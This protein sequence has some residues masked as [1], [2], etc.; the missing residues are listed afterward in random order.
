MVLSCKPFA[1]K[2]KEEIRDYLKHTTI[3]NREPCLCVIQVGDNPA[4]NSYIKGKKKDCEDVGIKFIHH[5]IVNENISEDEL[6]DIIN[7]YNDDN[8]VDGI[9]VQLPLPSHLDERIIC[10]C[11]DLFKDVDGF[12]D[13][14]IFTPCTP[15]GIMRIISECGI[16]LAG[17][18]CVMV[19]SGRVGRPTGNL[20]MD[21]KATVTF[22][23]SKTDGL[24]YLTYMADVI[25]V[26]AGRPH[27]IKSNWI[28]NDTLIIDVGIN[29]DENGKL[30]G[31]VDRIFD[32]HPNITITPVPG[33]VGLMTRVSLLEN[34][35][36]AYAFNIT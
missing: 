36:K 20:M 17:K 23:N 3:W 11:V 27:M 31:D 13:D 4:S 16:D 21:K 25:V 29:R 14:A 33:G 35:I 6:I 34:V 10:N 28:S 19:G 32:D 24:G 7:L 26:A 5:H 1:D 18:H 2:I 12:R 9:I 22:C 15:K 8:T 30:I